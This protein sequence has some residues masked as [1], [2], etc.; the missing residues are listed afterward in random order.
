M[1][2][3]LWFFLNRPGL[4][5][6]LLPFLLF[7]CLWG[8]SYRLRKKTQGK[9][10]A[11]QN[12]PAQRED[13][14]LPLPSISPY[15][16]FSDEQMLLPPEHSEGLLSKAHFWATDY[17][18]THFAVISVLGAV[19]FGG[20]AVTSVLSRM[21]FPSIW[22]ILFGVLL[23]F[24]YPVFVGVTILFVNKL[25]GMILRRIGKLKR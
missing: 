8:V 21:K 19:A 7:F 15:Y 1:N 3:V 14:P 4:M 18:V 5:A 13:V 16:R 9:Q 22:A 24:S 17:L 11:E 25:S 20:I 6:G 23:F 2:L 10:Q 12:T